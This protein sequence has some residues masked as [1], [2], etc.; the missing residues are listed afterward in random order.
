MLKEQ[1]QLILNS[2]IFMF[3]SLI[4]YLS[5]LTSCIPPST[6]PG[7]EK[8][9]DSITA[10]HPNPYIKADSLPPAPPPPVLA[11]ATPRPDLHIKSDTINLPIDKENYETYDRE[12]LNAIIDY[13]PTLYQFPPLS[14]D[15]SYEASGIT[16]DYKDSSGEIQRLSFNSEIGMDGYYVIYAWFLTKKMSAAARSR[17]EKLAEIYRTINSISNRLERGGTRFGHMYRRIAGISLYD[18]Y[19][20]AHRKLPASTHFAADKKAFINTLKKYI[21]QRTD[22]DIKILEADEEV[23]TLILARATKLNNLITDSYDLK[24]AKEFI[25][26]Y[27]LK[28]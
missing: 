4:I 15:S 1:A 12:E 8:Q 14:P 13:F 21:H 9:T 17:A 5:L 26:E 28:E 10:A 23:K 18:G 6:H 22:A 19:M 7:K 24:M 11:T 25:Q 2:S 27:N 16:K 20:Y 3:R